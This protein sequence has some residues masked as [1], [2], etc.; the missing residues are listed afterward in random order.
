MPAFRLGDVG[1]FMA[2][3]GHQDEALRILDELKRR[4]DTGEE[5]ISYMWMGY[6]SYWLDNTETAIDYF[7]KSYEAREDFMFLI[8]VLP[9]FKDEE[10]RSNPIFQ[11]LITKLGFEI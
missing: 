3:I 10:L 6:I 5:D 9:E 8:N 2:Q 4:V 1:Y 11:A 7:E